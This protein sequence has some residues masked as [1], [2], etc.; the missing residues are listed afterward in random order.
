MCDENFDSIVL[1]VGE[2]TFESVLKTKLYFYPRVRNRRKGINYLFFYRI[3][4]IYAVTHYGIIEDVVDNADDLINVLEK[5]KF[6]ADPDKEA[7]AYK[8]S[9][10]IELPKPIIHKKGQPS[11]QHRLYTK[12][13]S[14][15]LSGTIMSLY[16]EK[17]KRTKR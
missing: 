4:P 8:L 13:H 12:F 9:K 14:F 7:S 5:M 10:I 3:A 11:I 16:S 15:I 2:Y 6:F 1:P 17:S